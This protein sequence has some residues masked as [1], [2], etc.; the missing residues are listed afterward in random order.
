MGYDQARKESACPRYRMWR[1]ISPDRRPVRDVVIG[2]AGR[3]D[4]CRL[5]SLPGFRLLCPPQNHLWTAG[6]AEIVAGC[7]IAMGL[8]GYPRRQDG[9]G[10][11]P[12][13][14]ERRE[15]GEPPRARSCRSGDNLH[16]LWP[17]RRSGCG[18][19]WTRSPTIVSGGSIFMMRFELGLERPDPTRAPIRC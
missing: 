4:T 9:S 13:S 8:G 2:M 7:A 12:T 19:S 1:N 15:Y 18:T 6:L 3:L 17:R 11:L 10:T 5:R 16:G 14:E